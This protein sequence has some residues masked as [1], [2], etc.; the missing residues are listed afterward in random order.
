M[1]NKRRD[2]LKSSL[3]AAIATQWP[4]QAWSA[5]E[6]RNVDPKDVKQVLV[7]QKCHLDVGYTDT[8]E[9]VMRKY[10]K[11]YYPKA[12][13]T[14]KKLR[15][16][17]GN[18][19]TWTTGSWM[20]YEYFEQASP[21]EQ[22]A[23]EQAIAAKDIAWHALPYTSETE[24]LDRSMID[25]CFSFSD[26]LDARTGMRTVAAKM[27]DVPGHTRGLVSA[28]ADH[29]VHLLDIG[30]NDMS[31]PPDVPDVFEWQAPDGKSVVVLYHKKDYGSV[32]Q[33]PGTDL[34][35]SV[36]VR[37]DNSGPPSEQEVNDLYRDLHQQF[38][39]ARLTAASLSDAALAI[40]AAKPRLP[41]F[42]QEIG[43]T[44]IYGAASDPEKMARFRELARLRQEWLAAG[45]LK[46]GDATDRNLLRRV[47]LVAEHTWGTDVK[48]YL[49]NGHYAKSELAEATKRPSYKIAMRSWQEK[50]ELV[51][52]G[53]AT[54]PPALRKEAVERLASLAVHT[55]ETS[56]MKALPAG[57]LIKTRH[58]ELRIDP[59]TGAIVQ[60]T[61]RARKRSWA[62][63]TRPLAL[64]SYQTLTGG[65]YQRYI[66]TY[67]N[68]EKWWAYQDFGKP[69]IGNYAVQSRSWTP[70]VKNVWI[71]EGNGQVEVLVESAIDDSDTDAKGA[72]AWPAKIY[73]RMVFPDAEA[74]IDCTLYTMGK[75][76][77]R[78]PEAMWL[79]FQ[80]DVA[81][82]AR[83]TMDKAGQSVSPLDVVR[84]G[85]RT[86]H[87]VTKGVYC[88]DG[89]DKL[90]ILTLDAPVLM[91]GEKS[92]LN[93]SLEMPDPNQG[94]HFCLFTNAWGTNYPQWA[95]GDWKFRF[96]I[97][98]RA[99]SGA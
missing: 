95:G 12:M 97:D 1:D 66:K 43:D 50:R 59:A 83:W 35:I 99:K 9:N 78:L 5:P 49:D 91:L 58:F 61:D 29:G 54:L 67:A 15:E 13:A 85:S 10:F 56:G 53:I 80:P 18:R 75:D 88:Q 32:L 23:M 40:R 65:D 17:G 36:A 26:A 2:L 68:P 81:K 38:P 96:T 63:P 30:V 74:K 73:H 71:V 77:N 45:Q 22:R 79:T 60:L 64:F 87:A 19:L 98:C 90:N 3:I 93:F 70:T 72:V 44:W 42:T 7:I 48:K 94:V 69:L 16:S 57:Q 21:E 33:I 25:G 41:A 62:S 28:L 20:L 31:T 86:Q 51:D 14:A 47:A 27:S 82:R 39:N 37:V 34:A 89:L 4:K 6:Y 55:P 76:A 24:L 11:E 8:Q 92:P 84:G 52:A 46:V